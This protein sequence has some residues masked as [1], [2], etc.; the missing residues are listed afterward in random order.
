M[1]KDPDTEAEGQTH[2]EE[3]EGRE[4]DMDDTEL[5]EN[6]EHGRRY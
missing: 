5:S 3:V 4:D 2:E 6:I 1:A